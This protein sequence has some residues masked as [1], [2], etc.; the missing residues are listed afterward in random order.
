AAMRGAIAAGEAQLAMRLAA[1][2]GWYW[3]LGGRRTEGLELMIAATNIHGDVTDDVRAMTY[4]LV[5]HFVTS[6]RGDAQQAAHWIHQAYRFTRQVQHRNPLL[7]LVVPL[8]RMLEAEEASVPAFEPLL[9]SADPWVR[10]VARLQLGK[11][12]IML[13]QGGRDADAYLEAALAEFRA[14]GERFGM[15]FALTELADRI[16]TRG[17][18]ATACEYYEQ[19]VAVVTEIGAVE[20][21]IRMRSRQAQLYWL[22]GD[23]D[24]SAAAIVEAQRCAEG[25]T[26]PYALVE[27]A[28]AKVALA[29]LR[30]D[31]EQAR[32][33]LDMA[34]LFMGED[35]E[36][37]NI[38]AG[39]QDLMGYLA[40]DLEVAR[41]HRRAACQAA[42][43]AGHPTMLA[44]VLVGVADFAL[45]IDQHERAAQLLAASVG[46]RGLPDR[47]DPDAARIE[48][49]ARRHLGEARLAE[50]T[51][52]GRQANWS[53]LVELT[54]GS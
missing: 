40:N 37:P 47:S 6:G 20:D 28:L 26:W 2:A 51:V 18:F 24:A 54:L 4:A 1:A 49:E 36:Q 43:D 15:S 11:A 52:E 7:E 23:P 8:E 45:R 21:V 22:L 27:L 48:R 32:H 34:V 14:I 29:R 46:F 42:V 53:Q 5:V 13:G 25:V 17:E 3:W 38:R 31:V 39:I 9:D 10:A 41:T 12:R 35:V 44:Q 50:V 16:A 33:Q 19:A 30:G